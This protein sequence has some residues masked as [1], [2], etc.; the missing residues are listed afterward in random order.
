MISTLNRMIS[1]MSYYNII[2]IS[3]PIHGGK[4]VVSL[5]IG[6]L[7]AGGLLSIH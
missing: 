7:V 2:I 5:K 3:A 1:M 4:S 6:G